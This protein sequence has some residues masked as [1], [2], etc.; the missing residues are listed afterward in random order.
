M[1]ARPALCGGRQATGVP[2]AIRDK[3]ME[4]V[5][6]DWLEENKLKYR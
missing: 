4:R 1:S 3:A 6:R 2:A 5:A